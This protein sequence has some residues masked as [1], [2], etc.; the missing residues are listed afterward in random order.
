M[1]SAPTAPAQH[2]EPYGAINRLIAT[3]LLWKQLGEL[4]SSWWTCTNDVQIRI[5]PNSATNVKALDWYI[6]ECEKE[7]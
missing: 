6:D 3:E 7:R 5:Q 4:S 2:Q 1:K